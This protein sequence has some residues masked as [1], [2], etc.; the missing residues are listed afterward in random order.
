MSFNFWLFEM[1][2]VNNVIRVVILEEVIGLW[3]IE[4][5]KMEIYVFKDKENFEMKLKVFILF[6]KLKGEEY[7]LVIFLFDRL[8]L[9]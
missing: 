7:E 3:N 1:I 8:K 2:F 9:I 6:N 4:V 5:E